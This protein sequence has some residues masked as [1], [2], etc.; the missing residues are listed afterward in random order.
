LIAI[1]NYVLKVGNKRRAARGGKNFR[2][3]SRSFLRGINSQ[4]LP[5]KKG[6]GGRERWTRE[7]I[8]VDKVM[9]T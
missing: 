3:R 6:R 2:H 7:G 1:D 4:R 5:K 9:K 8:N